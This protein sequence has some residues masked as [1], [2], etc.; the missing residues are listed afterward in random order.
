MSEHWYDRDGGSQY[1]ADLR[2]ARKFGYLPSV[3]TVMNV[4][5]KAALTQWLVRQGILA[6]LTGT[7]GV[8]E[9]DDAYIA[10]ILADSKQQS[11]DAANEGTRI[12]D[13]C[14]QHYNGGDYPE[15]Y[16]PHAIAAHAEIF[17]LF[18]DVNDWV[19]EKSFAHASGFGGKVDLHSPSTGIVVDFKTKDGDFS[20]GEKLAWDQNIQLAAYQIG[21]AITTVA[22]DYPNNSWIGPG[23]CRFTQ[24]AN[25]FVSRTHPGKVASHVWSAQDI[26]HGWSVF[27]AALTLWKRVKKYDASY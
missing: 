22:A 23:W 16:Q 4:V 2:K 13:A 5:D 15:T 18:P 19:S 11:I 3:T 10:R 8:G 6:A 9:S 25:I 1:D 12:H 20:D 7:R 14:E 26:A 17:R 24:C 21:L 27:E